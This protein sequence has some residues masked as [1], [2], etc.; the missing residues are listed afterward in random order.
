MLA[1]GMPRPASSIRTLLATALRSRREEL[2]LTQDAAAE[3]CGI[4]ARYWRQIET[5]K[6]SPTFDVL[7]NALQA[8]EWTWPDLAEHLH[9][10]RRSEKHAPAA[11]HRLLDEAWAAADK[12]DR[13]LLRAAL[14]TVELGLD[15][16]T[17]DKK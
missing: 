5:G 1:R 10:A 9:P 6:H 2:G 17:R 7:D 16:A 13:E 14:R 8:L 15:I 12:K 11:T 4:N 3:R